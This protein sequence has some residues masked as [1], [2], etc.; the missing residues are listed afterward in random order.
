[1]AHL[2]DIK[3]EY[4]EVMRMT[5]DPDMP[6][7]AI[8]DTL[9]AISGEFNSKALN[10]A[11]VISSLNAEA[12]AM[13][14]VIKRITDRKAATLNKAQRL[15]EYLSENMLAVGMTKVQDAEI[16]LSFRKSPD[17]VVIDNPDLLPAS[18]LKTTVAP[19]K[20]E[21]KKIIDDLPEGAAHIETGKQTLVIK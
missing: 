13:A 12:D 16:Q 7:Q 20:A 8:I 9:E 6:E 1:M 3:N 5:D 10:V 15:R 11:K 4:L 18:C 14:V 2:Y 17:S 19:I 21:V